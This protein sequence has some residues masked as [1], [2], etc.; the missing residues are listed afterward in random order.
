MKKTHKASP[1]NGSG[2]HRAGVDVSRPGSHT[3][4]SLKDKAEHIA[5][6]SNGNNSTADRDTVEFVLGDGTKRE[7]AWIETPVL[8]AEKVQACLDKAERDNDRP[9]ATYGYDQKTLVK[10][11]QAM[12]ASAAQVVTSLGASPSLTDE[13]IV[14]YAMTDIRDLLPNRR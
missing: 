8:P 12:V 2:S 14:S 6:A 10:L 7:V 3:A 11:Q 1:S 4:V 5:L 13:E 9:S